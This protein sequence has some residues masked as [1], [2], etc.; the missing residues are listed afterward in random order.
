MIKLYCGT[1][2]SGK[3]LAVIR[4]LLH[5][6]SE[7]KK[8]YINI[9]GFNIELF[10]KAT[11]NYDIEIV[12]F[13]P[14]T[15]PKDLLLLFTDI[16]DDAEELPESERIKTLLIYDEASFSLRDY[17]TRDDLSQELSNFIA[18]HRHYGPCDMIWLTQGQGKIHTKFKEDVEN[19]Y[20]ALSFVKR[21]DPE[22]DI[23]FDEM[24]PDD[25]K[26]V[27]QGGQARIK[28]KKMELFR[29][30][31]GVDY[32]YFDFYVSGD[33]GR[34]KKRVNGWKKYIYLLGFLLLVVVVLFYY[35]F[36]KLFSS[37]S[38]H[39]PKA[40]TK[41]EKQS[42][43]IKAVD[44]NVT[45]EKKEPDPFDKYDKNYKKMNTQRLFKIFYINGF[46]YLGDVVLS[47]KDFLFF[48]EDNSIRLMTKQSITKDSYYVLAVIEL[49]VANALGLIK[50]FDFNKNSSNNKDMTLKNE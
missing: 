32:H 23:V 25:S 10:R 44:L 6:H 48:V 12:T 34:A 20:D 28:F 33:A 30:A 13:D 22:N 24:D 8:L 14:H 11:G 38:A 17:S 36:S 39:E 16:K 26:K 9:A 37:V 18:L 40:D 31:D 41:I 45:E 46:Y 15:Y 4:D 21:V 7:Y 35:T 27:L 29:G 3:S 19:Y 1:G 5:N 2:G 43:P 50:D 47:S 42:Q 49:N